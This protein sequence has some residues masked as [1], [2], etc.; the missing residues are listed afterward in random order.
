M[1][2]RSGC[3]TGDHDSYGECCRSATI[4]TAYLRPMH[5]RSAEKRWNGE[6]AEYRAL[7]AQGIQPAGTTRQALDNA[8]RISDATGR[9]YNAGS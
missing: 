6:L 3:P 1:S 5:D 2:C 4:G 9:A 7:K 8:K